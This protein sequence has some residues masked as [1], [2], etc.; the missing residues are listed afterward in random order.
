[1]RSCSASPCGTSKGTRAAVSVRLARTMRW[2][3]VGSGTRNARAISVV[4]R[5]PSKRSVS[6]TWASLDSTGWQAVN[7][8]RSRSSPIRSRSSSASLKSGTTWSPRASASAP[9]SSCLRRCSA[10]W[11]SRSRA[12]FLAV[13]INQAAGLSGMPSRGQCSSAA[14]R[15]S[16]ASSSAR[17]T[18]RTM[19]ASAPMILA[20]SMRQTASIAACRS[21]A[22]RRETTCAGLRRQRAGDPPA[23]AARA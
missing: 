13:A 6:A 8:S 11:R 7:T 5:P 19:R 22:I 20:A 3:M 14:T 18:S 2:A 17:P 15:A 21:R 16:C 9:S 10:C 23:R 4:V 1:M 12:R